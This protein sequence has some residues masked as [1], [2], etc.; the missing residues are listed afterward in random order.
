MNER[1]RQFRKALG[2]TQE[3]F[4]GKIGIRGASLSSLESGNSN[5]TERLIL[6]LCNV[7]NLNR[8]WLETG[9]GEMQV[10][11]DGT[12]ISE[13][14]GTFNLDELDKK[15]LQSYLNLPEQTRSAVKSWVVDLARTI[16]GVEAAAE[17]APELADE[18]IAQ[19]NADIVYEQTLL[20]RKSKGESGV[21]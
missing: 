10:E 2:Y 12:I 5:I 19:R 13:L 3:E 18:E 1:L 17:L 4:A 11:N 9:E 20:E 15:I 21:A 8:A 16:T 14:A 6:S 7:Y